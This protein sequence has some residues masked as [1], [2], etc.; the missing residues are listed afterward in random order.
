[1]TVGDLLRLGLVGLIGNAGGAAVVTGFTLYLAPTVL[2]AG[3]YAELQRR[4]IPALVVFTVTALV[5]GA[6]WV[7]LRPF[8][9]IA[10]WLAEDRAP[11]ESER[12]RVLRYP[13]D[14]AI[15]TFTLWMFAAVVGTAAGASVSTSAI[16]A[17]VFPTVLGAGMTC[18]VQYLMVERAIRP[19][20]AL[21]L[22][23]SEPPPVGRSRRGCAVERLLGTG[24]GSA[25]ARHRNLRRLRSR[26]GGVR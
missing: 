9:P 7:W 13:R 22:A 18:A 14:W 12:K 5:F 6:W 1:M 19:I 8:A 23:G 26:G 24:Y 20:T 15:R 21:V 16:P 25:A 3:E 2:S 4:S 11:T 17:G 10:R